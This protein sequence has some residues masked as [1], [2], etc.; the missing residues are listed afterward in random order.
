[1]YSQGRSRVYHPRFYL[2]KINCFF[3]KKNESVSCS[4]DWCQIQISIPP[5]ITSSENFTRTFLYLVIL[6]V[7]EWIKFLRRHLHQIQGNRAGRNFVKSCIACDVT[8]HYTCKNA[9]MNL[10]S[11]TTNRF[12]FQI[13]NTLMESWGYTW[14]GLTVIVTS[15]LFLLKML[16]TTGL[17]ENNGNDHSK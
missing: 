4:R 1:M 13:I 7:F 15:M 12:N 11:T 3:E 9:E 14:P 17:H 2:W 5:C 6:K 10:K 8:A 16:N